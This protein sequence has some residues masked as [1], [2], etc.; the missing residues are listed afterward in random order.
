MTAY[1][2]DTSVLGRVGRSA[3]VAERLADLRRA[4][5]LWTCDLV[6]LEIGYSARNDSEWRAVRDAQAALP[7]A[8]VTSETLARAIE[9]QGALAR[10]GHHR[11]AVP[12][13]IIAASAEQAEVAVLHYD[14]DFESIAQETRQPVEWVTRPGSID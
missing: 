6:T 12:D 5:A 14:H 11:V 8:T 2:V 13:L 10:R 4:G 1:L 3:V 9:V 7:Q